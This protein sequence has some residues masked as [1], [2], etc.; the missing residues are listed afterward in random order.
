VLRATGV[1]ATYS[2]PAADGRGRD[3]VY[4]SVLKAEWPQV[5]EQLRTRP[6]VVHAEAGR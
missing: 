3:A 6:E 2:N 1:H 5:K 4:Y